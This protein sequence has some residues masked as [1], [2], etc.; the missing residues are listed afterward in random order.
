V[1]FSF[2]SAGRVKFVSGALSGVTTNYIYPNTTVSYAP[3]G[4]LSSLTLGNN[5]Q[6]TVSYNSKFQPTTIQAGTILTLTYGY[7]TTQNN[8]NLLSQT[9]QR[10]SWSVTQMYPNSSYDGVN[11]LIGASETNG[12]PPA[13]WVETY[14]YDKFGNRALS[15]TLPQTNETPASLTWFNTDTNQINGSSG[16]L[17]WTY[18]AAGNVAAIQG[19]PRSFVYDAE[20]RQVSA[21]IGGVTSSYVYDGNGR[22][23]QKTAPQGTTNYV[24]DAAGQLAAEYSTAPATDTGTSYLV[25][26]HLGST[27]LVM[28]QN[29]GTK[30]YDYLPFGGEIPSTVGSRPA[31]YG[32]VIYPSSPDVL[33]E[34]FTGKERDAETGMD[35]FGVRYMSNAQGRFMS[36]DPVGPSSDEIRNPQK[37]N[38]YAYVVNNPLTLVDPDGSSDTPASPAFENVLRTSKDLYDVI[39][40]SPNYSQQAF[41][42]QLRN[43]T[44]E[45]DKLFGLAGNAVVL[46]DYRKE[47]A[48][49]P[50]TGLGLVGLGN[51]RRT[52]DIGAAAPSND[53]ITATILNDATGVGAVAKPNLFAF[54]EVKSGS[55]NY[56]TVLGGIEQIRTAP[57]VNAFAGVSVPILAV[58]RQEFSSLNSQER[59]LLISYAKALGVRIQLIPDLNKRAK[60]LSKNAQEQLAP[61]A[62]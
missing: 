16:G 6:E 34:K 5:I 25:E 56:S 31:C 17:G 33:S 2:D 37:W 59:G 10:G 8:G 1:S 40:A 51:D 41:Q 43:N 57:I 35:F 29:S 38:R 61:V 3:N 24:Y 27:R 44:V 36:P 21:T 62:K 11:R 54:V 47:T 48:A 55:L 15:S 39:R 7:S 18:D 30:C 26:D 19:M 46:G 45:Q 28:E 32:N 12:S 13:N 60:E 52:P 49:Q 14:S 9:I 42:Q 23:V 4:S 50:E 20:N 58:D 22:R 53:Q